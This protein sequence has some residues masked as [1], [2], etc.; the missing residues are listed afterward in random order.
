MED[1]IPPQIPD[2]E[3]AALLYQMPSCCSK[4]SLPSVTICSAIW[5]DSATLS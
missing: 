2:S 5:A 1:V 4:P 3:N